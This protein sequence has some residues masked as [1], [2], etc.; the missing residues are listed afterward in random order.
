V[1]TDGLG[2]RRP[3]INERCVLGAIRI[4]ALWCGKQRS[5]QALQAKTALLSA[6][7]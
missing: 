2:A 6:Q 5:D 3:S 7:F 4:T 1:Q